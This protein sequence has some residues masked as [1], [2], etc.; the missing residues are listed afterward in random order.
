LHYGDVTDNHFMERVIEK[1]QPNEIYNLAAQTHVQHS[2]EMPG[3]TIDVNFKGLVNICEA[4]LKIPKFI[5]KV[6]VFQASTSEMYG[7]ISS[8]DCDLVKMNEN[9]PF[10]PMSP[11]AV[12]KIASF[13]LVK[14][15]RN[16]YK[17]KISTAI[18]FNHESPLRHP[19]FITRKITQGIAKIKYGLCPSPLKLGNLNAI[20]DWGHAEEFVRAFWMVCNQDY[21]REFRNKGT[22]E[23]KN[24]LEVLTDYV[25]ATEYSMTVRE[26]LLRTC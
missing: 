16:V 9:Y 11:Y 5:E 23:R 10:N 18:S 4:I 13:H 24:R 22:S 25:V 6:R 7:E 2:F 8:E 20:R 26:F 15:Y 1:C 21:I 17:M 3:H 19:S 12:S 14:Y